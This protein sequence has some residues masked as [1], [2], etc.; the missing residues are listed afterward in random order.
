MKQVQ[1][2]Y[3]RE[4]NAHCAILEANSGSLKV[5]VH[6]DRYENLTELDELFLYNFD[7]DSNCI[8]FAFGTRRE[9]V[10]EKM[11]ITYNTDGTIH[12]PPFRVEI[13]HQL[14]TVHLEK[15]AFTISYEE[16]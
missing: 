2:E 8:E 11:F 1:T 16:V 5:L 13:S 6:V 10:E 3:V 9:N 12:R 14:D 4:M 7:A 15:Y